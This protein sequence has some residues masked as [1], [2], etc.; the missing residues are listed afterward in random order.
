[1]D[2]LI[3][4][5]ETITRSVW[6]KGLMVEMRHGD[7]I[8]IGDLTVSHPGRKLT[9]FGVNDG[10]SYRAEPDGHWSRVP[11]PDDCPCGHEWRHRRHLSSLAI[12]EH[13]LDGSATGTAALPLFEAD[14]VTH[15]VKRA[16]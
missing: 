12:I 8:A 11:A 10:W 6:G 5:P 2:E 7:L 16:F 13:Q 9:G 4:I 15:S 3:W 14:G 1:V